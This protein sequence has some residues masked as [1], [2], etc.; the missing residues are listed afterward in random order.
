M[1]DWEELQRTPELNGLHF[2]AERP[3]DP[4]R[5]LFRCLVCGMA[6][7]VQNADM[8]DATD[9][10]SGFGRQHTDCRMGVTVSV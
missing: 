1:S 9:V 10:L 8:K 7:R 2:Y 3:P 4:A 5:Y 6:L